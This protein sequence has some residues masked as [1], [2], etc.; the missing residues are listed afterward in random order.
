MPTDKKGLISFIGSCKTCADGAQFGDPVGKA[1]KAKY[2]E[3]LN[4]FKVRFGDDP[5][6][7]ALIEIYLPKKKKFGIL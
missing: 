2:Q 7:M 5:E 4:M 6:A 1:W 3:A